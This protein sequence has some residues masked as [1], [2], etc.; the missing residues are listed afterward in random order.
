MPRFGGHLD[1]AQVSPPLAP[2][3]GRTVVY[4]KSNGNV[5][6]KGPDGIEYSLTQNVF[7]QQSP[8]SMP[9]AGLWVEL[10]ADGTIK[11]MWAGTI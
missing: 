3:S 4:P 9:T 2:V 8:P 11:T 1:I 10:N 7:I 6:S 5:Y